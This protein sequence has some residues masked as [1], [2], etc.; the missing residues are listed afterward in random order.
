LVPL[1][2]SRFDFSPLKKY[3]DAIPVKF[4]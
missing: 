4:D 2:L 1:K 3:L